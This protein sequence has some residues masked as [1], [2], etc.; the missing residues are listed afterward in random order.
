MNILKNINFLLKDSKNRRIL[1]A[2][3]V[4]MSIVIAGVVFFSF[5]RN[6]LTLTEENEVVNQNEISVR[7]VTTEVNYD[8]EE[9]D[10]GEYILT[11]SPATDVA[12]PGKSVG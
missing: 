4:V 11:I 6:A 8:Y 10:T 9:L 5:E 7:S 1:Y 12:L 3:I 2:T